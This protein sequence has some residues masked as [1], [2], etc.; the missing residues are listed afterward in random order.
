MVHPAPA[1]EAL[2]SRFTVMVDR[3]NAPV[4][5]ARAAVIA[6]LAMPGVAQFGEAAFTS[7]DI[8]GSVTVTVTAAEGV[9]AAKILPSSERHCSENLWEQGE[10]HNRKAVESDRGGQWRL[11]EF[12]P[13]FRQSAGDQ[14]S[15]GR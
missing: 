6:A 2:S 11:D 15:T 5:V 12:A 9:R 4:Y 8:G 14:R 13:S 1:G 7:F 3:Q 10:L